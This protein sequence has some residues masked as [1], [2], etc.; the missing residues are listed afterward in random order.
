MIKILKK[1]G[2]DGMYFN[3]TKA[4]FDKPTANITFESLK[5]FPLD[6]E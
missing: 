1:F 5:C 6:Q 2:M 4:V 3:I